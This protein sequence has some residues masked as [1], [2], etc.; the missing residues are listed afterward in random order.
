MRYGYEIENMYMILNPL[1]ENFYDDSI[2]NIYPNS[3]KITNYQNYSSES[4]ERIPIEELKQ[5]IK[6]SNLI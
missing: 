1:F 4:V 2:S 5:I 6:N 3:K